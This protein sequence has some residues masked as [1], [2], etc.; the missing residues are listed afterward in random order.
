MNKGCDNVKLK[1][2]LVLCTITIIIGIAMVFFSE[3]RSEKCT[4]KSNQTLTE[5]KQELAEQ[6][7]LQPSDLTVY[8]SGEYRGDNQYRYRVHKSDSSQDSDYEAYTSIVEPHYEDSV[9][10][11]S[12]VRKLL[13]KSVD[14]SYDSDRW[15]WVGFFAIVAVAMGVI[16]IPVSIG[17]KIYEMV[18]SD[19]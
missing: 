14:L 1:Q 18:V 9:I 17:I 8:W 10:Q 15:L 3:Y 7:N 13:K 2:K 19:E 16:M 4:V 5:A 12:E 6:L 11:S